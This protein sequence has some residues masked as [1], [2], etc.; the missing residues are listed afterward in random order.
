MSRSPVM[1][2]STSPPRHSRVCEA[3]QVLG[4]FTYGPTMGAQLTPY[5]P[6][7][8][9][10]DDNL[11]TYLGSRSAVVYLATCHGDEF[12]MLGQSYDWGNLSRAIQSGVEL[13]AQAI[14][15]VATGP[16]L[17]AEASAATRI[18]VD[19]LE[20][21]GAVA[22]AAN[23]APRLAQDMAANPAAPRALPLERPVG[24]SAS[25]NAFVQKRIAGLQ[26]SGA[27]RIRV[28]QQQV[29]INGT[30]SG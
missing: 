13:E 20:D 19:A 12:C 8:L 25:Q 24:G 22:H 26:E 5:G 3:P 1:E 9:I 4:R 30:R 21:A 17:G 16:L 28:N 23:T 10:T 29:D 2:R 14:L 18:L 6:V 11:T 27:T 7:T 15:K